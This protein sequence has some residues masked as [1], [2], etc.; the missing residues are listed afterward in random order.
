M[1]DNRPIFLVRKR[2]FPFTVRTPAND[3]GRPRSGSGTRAA[4]VDSRGRGPA[5]VVER[6][7]A[8]RARSR[9]VRASGLFCGARHARSVGGWQHP[10]AWRGPRPRRLPALHSERAWLFVRVAFREFGFGKT[11]TRRRRENAISFRHR[12]AGEG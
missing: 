12:E 8:Q 6:R 9:A 7:E 11:R 1:L 2:I 4:A 3:A 5:M 10:S